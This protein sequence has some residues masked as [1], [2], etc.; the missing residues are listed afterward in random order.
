MEGEPARPGP[1]EAPETLASPT[2][3]AEN[4]TGPSD[5]GAGDGANCPL[6][7]PMSCVPSPPSWSNQIQ[8]IIGLRCGACH[9][10]GGIERSRWDFSTYQGVHKTFGAILSQV[11]GCIMPPSDAAALAP[12]ERLALLEWLVCAAPNN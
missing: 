1:G 9:G 8:G 11:Y 4:D 7:L 10:D 12:N 6:D 2:D 5:A 3:A